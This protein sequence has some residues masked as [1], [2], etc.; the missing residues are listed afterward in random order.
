VSPAARRKRATAVVVSGTPRRLHGTV[1]GTVDASALSV[2]LE[3][4]EVRQLTVFPTKRDSPDTIRFAIHVAPETPPGRYEGTVDLGEHSVPIV[5]DVTAY[6]NVRSEPQTLMLEASAEATVTTSV[7]MHN[8]GNVPCEIPTKST[9]CLFDGSGFE[10][11]FWAALTTEPTP[12][13]RRIDILMDDLA[14]YHGGLVRIR[15]AGRHPPIAP[16][17]TREL[18]VSLRFSDRVRPQ[19]SYVGAWD[20]PGVR[21]PIRVHGVGPSGPAEPESE[22]S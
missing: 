19:R 17:E 4:A 1:E 2:A 15:P 3:G 11:A 20:L 14:D 5:A 16:G 22:V 7:L 10:H 18:K 13:R 9:F 12:E 21:L 8:A 6:P